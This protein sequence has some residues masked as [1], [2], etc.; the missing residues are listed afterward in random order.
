MDIGNVVVDECCVNVPAR[1]IDDAWI[2][3]IILKGAIVSEQQTR[4]ADLSECDHMFVVRST[5]VASDDFVGSRINVRIV[6]VSDLL[7]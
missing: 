1:A 5:F 3:E 4:T 2:S 6:N 7:G